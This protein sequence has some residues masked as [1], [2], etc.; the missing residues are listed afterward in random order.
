MDA[1]EYVL[2][3]VWLVFV[4]TVMLVMLRSIW[5]GELFKKGGS[6]G[7]FG[8]RSIHLS[9]R[10]PGP[11][12]LGIL[13]MFCLLFSLAVRNWGGA[14]GVSI[15]GIAVAISLWE[16]RRYPCCYDSAGRL[17]ED[18]C[19]VSDVGDTAGAHR[20]DDNGAIPEHPAD[21]TRDSD[22]AG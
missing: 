4:V 16:R 22:C 8:G 14:I 19:S 21:D 9:S 6:S 3:G 20:V 11:R 2:T 15:P 18:G 10:L 1:A 7:G 13:L 17:R 5:R 12:G